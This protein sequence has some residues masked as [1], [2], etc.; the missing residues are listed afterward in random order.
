MINLVFRGL[1]RFNAKFK[2]ENY[3]S[4]DF[5]TMCGLLREKYQLHN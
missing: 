2:L 4:E 5:A 1:A 3:T